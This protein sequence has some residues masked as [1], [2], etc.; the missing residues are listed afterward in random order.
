MFLGINILE[1][2]NLPIVI[3][4]IIL[5]IQLYISMFIFLSK[6]ICPWCGLPFFAFGKY[7]L[8]WNGIKF[9]FQKKCIN[10]QQPDIE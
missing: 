2:L 5:A 7:G 4:I 10:C 9:I 8:S 1:I 6:N 3:L